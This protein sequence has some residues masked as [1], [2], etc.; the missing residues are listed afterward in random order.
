MQRWL[1]CKRLSGT[2]KAVPRYVCK[3]NERVS[4]V[5]WLAAWVWT[6]WNDE[7]VDDAMPSGKF[8]S[9]EGGILEE[10]AQG[11]GQA[12]QGHRE[13]NSALVPIRLAPPR[14]RLTARPRVPV[15]GR[16]G[17]PTNRIADR[18]GLPMLLS[19]G[20]DPPIAWSHCW[21]PYLAHPCKG[22]G[23]LEY[24]SQLIRFKI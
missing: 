24:T 10:D 12:R 19:L 22:A 14:P 17:S 2:P 13:L 21:A 4:G 6:W 18:G 3:K 16:R 8:G 15:A 11:M 20:P 1:A 9:S 7:W 5:W 23:G